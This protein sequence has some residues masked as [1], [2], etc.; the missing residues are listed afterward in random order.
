MRF[1]NTAGSGILTRLEILFDDT[2]PNGIVRLGVYADQS[3]V[4]G[5]LLLDAG[6]AAVA[7][8]WVAKE[9]LSLA[10]TPNTYYW[11]AFVLQNSNGVRY[12]SARPANSHH[13]FAYTYGALPNQFASAGSNN[14][15]Y[16]MRATVA[17]GGP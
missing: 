9:G 13:W 8:G 15:Q 3:G 2:T 16:V 14:N 7:N 12:Q 4:P 10:V 5:R 1:Q 11:L 17:I 6:E